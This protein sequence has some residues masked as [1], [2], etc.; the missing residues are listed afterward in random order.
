[1]LDQFLEVKKG[2]RTV[3][4]IIGWWELRRIL[5]NII[6]FIGAMLSWTIMYAV[7][8]L[9]AGEDLQ[10]PLA[11]IGFIILCNIGYTL[12]WLVEIGLGETSGP[13]S[14]MFKLGTYITLGVIF[15][16]AVLHIIFWIFSLIN[17]L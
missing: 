4:Q 5:Y 14:G 6:I 11:I 2:K 8:S 1:M 10:E 16:P 13:S 17:G 3:V 9:D 15:L 7:V 12:G